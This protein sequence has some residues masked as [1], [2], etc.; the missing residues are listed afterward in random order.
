MSEHR[1]EHS[2]N[3]TSITYLSCVMQKKGFNV[4]VLHDNSNFYMPDQSLMADLLF[5]VW[6]SLKA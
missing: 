3:K 5:F 4:A 6:T 1:L 2:A